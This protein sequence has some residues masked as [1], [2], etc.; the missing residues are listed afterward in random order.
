MKKQ[1]G[2]PIRLVC[3]SLMALGLVLAS[4]PVE[5]LEVNY[6]VTFNTNGGGGTVPAAQ[7][8]NGGR[9]ILPSGNG[10]T[11]NGYTFGG[12]NI[13]SSGTGTNYSAGSYYTV[14]GD[15]TLYAK[16][17]TAKT[18]NYTVTFNANGGSGTV[19][20]V[21]TVND[22]ESITLPSGSGLSKTGYTFDGW[23]TSASGTGTNYSAGSS[24]TVTGDVTLY[25]K[26]I[27]AGTTNYTVTFNV[28][29]GSGTTPSA[30][31]VTAGS[32]ITLPGG[33]GLSRSGYTFGGWNANEDGM[34]TNYNAGSSYT[35]TGNTSLYAKWDVITQTVSPNRFEYYWVDQHGN[36]VTTSGGAISIANGATLVITAQGTGYVVQQWRLNGRDTG[37]SENT[38]NFSSTT[39]G[40]HTISLFVEKDGKLY[41]TNII[42]TVGTAFTVSFNINNGSGTVP[43]TQTV[44]SGSSIT[45]PSGN[46]LTR[47][48]YTFG[49]WNTNTY[50]TGTNYS[51]GSSY[52]P[53]GNI[54]LYAMWSSTGTGSG[55]E[56][57]PISLSNNAWTNGSI[58]STASGSAVWYSFSV[59]SGTTYY[60][61]WNDSYEGNSTKTL[62]VKV[63]AY[64]TS[65]TS[66]FT[67]VDSAWS[68][69]RS[70]TASSSGTV[71]IKVE[72]YSSGNTGT[73][74]VAY[75]TSSTRP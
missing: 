64:N 48:G 75:R 73:F 45:L 68:S 27:V 9:I 70:F 33:S 72:P 58:T 2:G 12:W 41:N 46:D 10:L 5:E 22:G 51:A 24:Y 15:V 53:T 44:A 8:V 71:K 19:P 17:I 52:T 67:S 20:A 34:G 35:V 42:I 1:K 49:G 29:G 23:N 25:A 65:G 37:H 18:T 32:S 38:Y 60:I 16:W 36:M 26:W 57:N 28:N 3:L 63:S 74:A 30:R 69:Y 54:T 13:N 14:T 40:N 62:D 11:R 43:S 50:G 59:T 55:T 47:S 66:I 4:C 56:A 39:A 31:T 7:M 61:W 6:T 21:Q